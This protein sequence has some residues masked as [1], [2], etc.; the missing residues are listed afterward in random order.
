MKKV[1]KTI[2]RKFFNEGRD[3]FI[4]PRY[5]KAEQGMMINNNKFNH[6]YDDFDKLVRAFEWFN[7]NYELGRY[8]N[9]YLVV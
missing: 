4:T 8:A 1:N 9:Y 7:C 5:Q 6:G 3:L 2:A